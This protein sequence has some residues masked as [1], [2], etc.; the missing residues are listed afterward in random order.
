M[1][2][3]DIGVKSDPLLVLR[4]R[5]HRTHYIQNIV[6]IPKF[7]EHLDG[8]LLFYTQNAFRL[9]VYDEPTEAK[10]RDKVGSI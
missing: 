3:T 8:L 2:K 4:V 5:S 6:T 1:I 7:V 10:R 9:N